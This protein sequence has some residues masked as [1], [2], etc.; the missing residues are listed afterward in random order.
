MLNIEFDSYD[1]EYYNSQFIPSLLEEL[2]N[3]NLLEES[4]GAMIINLE[5]YNLPPA[6]IVKSNGSSTYITRD[7]A[8]AIN[9]K[10]VYDFKKN[11]YVVA[12]QQNLHFQQLKAIIELM[13]YE[14]YKDCIHIP[15]GMVSMKDGAM[16]TRTGKVI[17]LE[18]V[19]NKSI[20]KTK[21]IIEDRK[22][23]ILNKDEISKDVGIGA[24]IFQELFNGRI[25]DYVF[26]WDILL[27]FD[28]ETGPYVQYTHARASSVLRKTDFNYMDNIKFSEIETDEE[29]A[30]LKNLY[31]FNDILI[32]ACEKNE[33]YI[34]TRYLVD[35]SKD[36]NKFYNSVN[37][38]N[39]S[40][41]NL[42]IRLF[43]TYVSKIVLSHGLK[44][45]GIKSP[46]R[47]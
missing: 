4:E 3:K 41:N 47:M 10:K 33:L 38:L 8:T 2:K 26:D 42:K 45:L 25:K 36:F 23:D 13:G 14:W 17:F 12:S 30:L 29:K 24:V 7:I 1:G 46:D 9:R 43:L 40:E 16:K 5:K 37:I 22:S 11:L 21:D 27:N 32:N 20:E 6:L 35:I 34:L 28:G 44:I 19:L 31:K 15:F 18:D 39:S